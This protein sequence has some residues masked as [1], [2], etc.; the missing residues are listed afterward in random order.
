MWSL[1][2][3]LFILRKIYA[4]GKTQL[5]SPVNYKY[6]NGRFQKNAENLPGIRII[7]VLQ[8]AT[9]QQDHERFY[10]QTTNPD[11]GTYYKF[12]TYQWNTGISWIVTVIQ[13]KE[14]LPYQTRQSDNSNKRVNGTEWL[15]SRGPIIGMDKLGNEVQ[16]S[17]TDPEVF[18]RPKVRY[19]LRERT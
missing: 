10:S 16:H 6:Q 17:F 2:I 9:E 7:K 4:L 5:T 13:T 8:K 15:K 3:C 11:T 14:N 1:S 12:R 19:E 18:Y